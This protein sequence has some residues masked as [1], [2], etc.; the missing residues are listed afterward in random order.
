MRILTSRIWMERRLGDITYQ[1]PFPD[2]TV[3]EEC[4][5]SAP[6]LMLIDDDEGLLLK[7]R[8][9]KVKVWPHDLTAI[10]LYLCTSCGKLFAAWNQG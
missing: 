6:V 1:A 2:A 7:Q 10:A 4:G 5:E 3:C 8:P 9:S